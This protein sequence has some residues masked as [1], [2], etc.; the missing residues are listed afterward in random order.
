MESL[1]ERGREKVGREV[2][3]G[4]RGA[5]RLLGVNWHEEPGV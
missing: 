4:V 3:G 1:A 5:G 2:G